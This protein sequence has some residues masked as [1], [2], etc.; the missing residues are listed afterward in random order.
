MRSTWGQIEDAGTANGWNV[1]HRFLGNGA[2]LEITRG[3]EW[4]SVVLDRQGRVTTA[5]VGKLGG[6]EINGSGK[7]ARLLEVLKTP[8]EQAQAAREGGNAPVMWVKTSGGADSVTPEPPA[9]PAT[10]VAVEGNR[11][12]YR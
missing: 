6:Y 7:L 2:T 3:S 9:L 8:Q 10:V 11:I 12:Y 1:M 4:V 5:R